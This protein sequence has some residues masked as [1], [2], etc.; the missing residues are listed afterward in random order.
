MRTVLDAYLAEVE[1]GLKGLPGGR[2][3]LMIRELSAHLLDEMEAR[4]L[5]GEEGL[6]AVLADK[7]SP[8]ALARSLAESDD[9]G[10]LHRSGTKLLAGALLALATG[11]YLFFLGR[12]W[13]LALT[14]GS[15]TGLAVG[16]GI[17]W[18]RRRWQRLHPAL[19]VAS[20]VL[21]GTLLAI[22]LGFTV[23]GL[24]FAPGRLA[25]G[26]FTGYLAERLRK[27]RSPW[28]WALDNVGFTCCIWF[29]SVV[30]TKQQTLGWANWDQVPKSMLFTFVLQAG[31]WAALRLHQLLDERWVLNPKG[32]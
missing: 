2:R 8:E 12:P 18:A 28:V 4:G 26:A 15:A 5:Q 29:I 11:G 9:E 7:E 32:A 31:V 1:A 3:R 23:P 16:A 21:L 17:F 19:R 13:Y 27:R 22:P 6:C 25:Y 30:V 14:I 10:F 24:A 20:A